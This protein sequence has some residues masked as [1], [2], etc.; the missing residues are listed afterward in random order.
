MTQ[1]NISFHLNLLRKDGLVT[2]KKVGKW[3]F[4]SLNEK[5]V[6]E[7][8]RRLAEAFNPRRAGKD[9]SHDSVFI[10][11]KRE[12]LCRAEILDRSGAARE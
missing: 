7:C 3:I 11:C 1:A 9:A 8:F 2:N 6:G 10:R 4:Y 5:A 12:D